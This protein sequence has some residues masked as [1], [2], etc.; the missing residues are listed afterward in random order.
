MEYAI[1]TAAACRAHGIKNVAVTAGFICEEP[2]K[3]LFAAMDAANVDLKAFTERFYEKRCAG[4]ARAGARDAQISRPRDERLDRDHDA[5]DPGRERRRRGDRG[6][7]P[8]DREGAEAGRSAPLHRLPS[9]LSHARDG[10]DA[11]RDAAEGAG[12]RDRATASSTS[13]SATS[14]IRRARRPCA[15]PAARARSAATATRSP[16][17]GST[18]RGACLSC[19]TKM[20]GVFA[21]KPG[22]WGS[23]RMP[24]TSSATRRDAPATG[25]TDEDEPTRRHDPQ[26]GLCA[27]G[28]RGL[29][30][31]AQRGV[32]AR[33]PARDGRRRGRPA[34]QSIRS[35]RRSTSRRNWR[36][37]HGVPVGFP[38]ERIAERASRA[39]ASPISCGLQ[40]A[41]GTIER[42]LG[43]GCHFQSPNRAFSEGSGASVWPL[44]AP[45]A[46]VATMNSRG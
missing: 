16:T 7:D 19:G 42:G 12:D 26:A 29:P 14:A 17:T 28:A 11:A 1:D 22:R 43:G 39:T 10:G 27:L 40:D 3:R 24:S 38:G 23:R 2:R 44:L 31:R 6:A 46:R 9:R 32:L 36:F 25:G 35:S 15:R 34:M 33:R 18:P 8:L 21:D 13:M 20:A 41:G 37:Q 4:Q 30:G 5:P 45:H